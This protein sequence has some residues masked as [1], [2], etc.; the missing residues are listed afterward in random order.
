MAIQHQPSRALLDELQE[1]D[2]TYELLP[3]AR[4]SS[5]VDEAKALGV[6]PEEVGKTLVL[7]AGSGLVRAVIPASERLDLEKVRSALGGESAELLSEQALAE[8]YP[9]FE[10]GAVPPIGGVRHDRILVDVGVCEHES[11]LLEAGTHSQSI[12]IAVGD[13]LGLEKALIAD[14]CLD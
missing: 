7:G 2:I 1:A 11:V 13:L 6:P 12:R 3:H 14:I 9:E 8:A 10:L 5:A 4:T